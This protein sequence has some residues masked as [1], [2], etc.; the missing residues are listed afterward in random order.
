MLQTVVYP[1]LKLV[2]IVLKL[3]PV[4]RYLQ[5]LGNVDKWLVVY[6]VYDY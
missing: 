3:S 1:K 5:K 4:E 6:N 2:E